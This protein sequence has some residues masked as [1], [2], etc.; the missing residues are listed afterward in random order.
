M[1]QK[2]YQLWSRSQGYLLPPR[3]E[4]WLPEEHLVHFI[5]DVVD[6]LDLSAIEGALRARD[7]RGQKSYHPRMM[8]A[9]LLYSYCTGVFSSRRIAQATFDDLATRYLSGDQHPHFTRVAAF[10]RDHLEA[11]AGL[12]V[13]TVQMCVKAG[14]VTLGHVA[15]DGTKIQANAS[16]HK[17]MSYERMTS[18]EKRLR[19]EMEA[20]L[21]RANSVD[22]E[23]DA[24]H[25]EEKEEFDLPTE[26]RRRETRLAR[27]Q[28]AK[29]ELEAE[30]KTTRA[31]H[32]R[33][34]AAQN[35]SRT[36]D[37]PTGKQR[38]A[39]ATRAERQRKE[40]EELIPEQDDDDDTPPPTLP[41]HRVQANTDGTPKSTAQRNFTDPESRIMVDGQ[42]AFTQG[43]NAQAAVCEKTQVILACPLSNQPPDAEY[44][45]PVL[46]EV[47]Q[48]MG[49][50]AHVVTADTGYWSA[51]NAAWCEEQGI[52][53]YIATGRTRRSDTTA[54]PPV[55]EALDARA[56]MTAK[57]QTSEGDARYRRRKATVE[58]VF[59]Q[60]KEA[61][62]FRRFLLRGLQKV[63][64]EWAM[65][66]A[67]HN[68][69]KLFR[70]QHLV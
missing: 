14:L 58:P 62:G 67:T 51:S 12:F 60:V 52:D 48:N 56:R 45:I 28:Q 21:A 39:A 31:D 22:A 59:G 1:A 8:V 36:V 15:I 57:L 65:I 41:T 50:P 20:L 42:G 44:L 54:D 26:L 10:R 33:K 70:F 7:A 40:A 53:V 37:A 47:E 27:I 17:A 16:K 63:G 43:Y 11:L 3:P 38:A 6:A 19:A 32:L 46:Q 66:C 55:D 34:L 69:L 68:L 24:R 61:R 29:A 25:G 13:Q 18:D 9:L 30:A 49:V 35:E 23:E 5:L 2:T 64:R 4:E